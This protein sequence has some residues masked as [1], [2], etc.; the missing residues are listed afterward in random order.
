VNYAN[1]TKSFMH[2]LKKDPPF[3]WDERVEESSD[4]LKKALVST[5]VLKPPNYNRDYLIYIAASKGMLGMV[6]V[7]GDY[8][9]QEHIVY[10]LSRNLVGLELK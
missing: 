9:L 8:E 4:A 1:L 10:Y 3:I 2:I 5:P 6:L 7:Q